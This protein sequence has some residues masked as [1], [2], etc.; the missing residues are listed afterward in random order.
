MKILRFNDDRIGILKKDDTVADVSDII[1]HRTERGPQGVMREL[2]DHFDRYRD[3]I[4]KI[5]VEKD[6]CPLNRLNLLAPVPCPS[7]C[8]AAFVNYL[9]KP[10]RTV[11]LLPNEFFHKAPELVGPEGLVQLLDIPP[12]LVFHAEAE[13][14]FIIARHAKNVAPEAAMDHVF[15]YVPFVDVGARGLTRRS[16]FLPK[17]QDTFAAC[18]P[19]ITTRD[20]I[21]DPYNLVVRSWVNGNPRQHY[22]TEFMAHK[23]S[24][25]VSWL[26]RFIQLQP[27]DVIAT[28]SFHDGL[29]PINPGDV[30][31]IEI[32]KL[33]K[34]RFYIGGDSPVKE[35]EYKAGRNLPPPT[36]MSITPV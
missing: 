20:E 18:G 22:N 28:G 23:I 2:I 27:G 29:G 34:A 24:D 31:E 6:G 5:L 33:G 36:G 30:F 16:Q 4:D 21:A 17:G 19:W 7:K 26:S 8:L 10:G 3:E 11:D 35:V 1:D 13:L 25:Q 14:A 32:E 9:D 12:V 15:G